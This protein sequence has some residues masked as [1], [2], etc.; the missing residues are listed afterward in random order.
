MLKQ[1]KQTK[2]ILLFFFKHINIIYREWGPPKELGLP[3]GG[4]G[5]P[6]SGLGDWKN[7]F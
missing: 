3:I 6:R 1:L 2:N 5:W 4:P 7:C